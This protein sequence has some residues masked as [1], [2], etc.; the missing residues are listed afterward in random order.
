MVNIMTMQD[1]HIEK[2]LISSEQLQQR[3]TEIGEEISRAYKGRELIV[4]G[5]LKGGIIF[6]SDLVRAIHIPVHLDFINVQ[7]YFGGTHSTGKVRLLRDVQL[8]IENKHLLI[9]DDIYDTGYTLDFLEALLSKRRPASVK[10][11]ALLVK[12]RSHE[13]P[14]SIDYHGF[15]I[16]DVFVVGYGL[17][18]KEYYRNLPYIAVLN[19][20]LLKDNL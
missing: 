6:L 16:P 13:R 19:Q 7:S 8:D 18:Y 3:I 20:N 2:I 10:I 4:V 1:Q 9:V 17:D 14:I 11:C 15:E 12:E 5:V